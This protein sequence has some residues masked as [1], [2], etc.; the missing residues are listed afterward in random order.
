[1]SS[2]QH[3]HPDLAPPWL[4][5][6]AD[7]V[8]AYVQPDGTWWINNTGFIRGERTLLSVDTCSTERRTRAYLDKVEEVAGE[9]TAARHAAAESI[10]RDRDDWRPW[11]VASRIERQLGHGDEADRDLARAKALNPRSALVDLA[12]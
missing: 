9:L 3:D 6:V 12:P 4:H 8:F 2:S 7:G 10:R 5:E 1:M 11:Y